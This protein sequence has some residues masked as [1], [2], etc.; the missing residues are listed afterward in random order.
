MAGA[1]SFDLGAIRSRKPGIFYL[2]YGSNLSLER[3]QNRCPNAVAVGTTMIPG[4]RMLFKKS[5]TGSY[6]TIEQDA[7]SCVPALVYKI[8]EYDEALLDHYE[9]YP[10]YYYKRFLRLPVTRLDSGRRMKEKKLCMVYVMHEERLLGEPSMEYFQLLDDGY[11]AWGFDTDILDRGLS[12]S[13]GEKTAKK[14]LEI[15]QG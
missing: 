10:K 14:Y 5:R 2:A 12:D 9:G 13:I 6:A 1:F 3:M 8:S 4:Y 7:N 11:A 15:Y